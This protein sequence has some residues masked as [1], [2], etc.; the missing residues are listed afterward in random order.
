MSATTSKLGVL[1]FSTCVL[2]VNQMQKGSSSNC[3]R[4][5]AKTKRSY[6]HEPRPHDLRKI[7]YWKTSH[8]SCGMCGTAGIQRQIDYIWLTPQIPERRGLSFVE[9]WPCLLCVVTYN[10]WMIEQCI[11]HKHKI[12]NFVGCRV[13]RQT[14]SAYSFILR[15]NSDK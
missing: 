11:F 13:C 8:F 15:M 5:H 14:F 9:R 12:S 3:R 6:R 4:W 10:L 1:K 2:N 7:Y